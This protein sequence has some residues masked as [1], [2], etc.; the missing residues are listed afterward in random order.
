LK[1]ALQS[2]SGAVTDVNAGDSMKAE[3]REAKEA[4]DYLKAQ[5]GA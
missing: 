5:G 2:K 1:R 4:Y 3:F